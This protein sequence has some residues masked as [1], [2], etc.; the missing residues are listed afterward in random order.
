VRRH[1]APDK[2][3]RRAS[4]DRADC[5][6]RLPA[7]RCDEFQVEHHH[8]DLYDF[9]VLWQLGLLIRSGF[10]RDRIV[11]RDVQRRHRRDVQRDERIRL[12]RR[13]RP[14]RGRRLAQWRD[15]RW[16]HLGVERLGLR[17]G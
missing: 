3:R 8:D 16:R 6:G 1:L 9:V 17:L 7:C 11:G 4:A 5:H 14:N 10:L 2:Y 13:L 12:G 15:V